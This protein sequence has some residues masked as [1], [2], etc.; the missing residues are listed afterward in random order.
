MMKSEIEELKLI[1]EKYKKAGEITV[2]PPMT[3]AQKLNA[4]RMIGNKGVRKPYVSSES[5]QKVQ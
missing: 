4:I 1:I 5:M 3:D 2:R